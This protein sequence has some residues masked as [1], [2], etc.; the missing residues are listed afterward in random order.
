MSNRR[1]DLYVLLRRAAISVPLWITLTAFSAHPGQPKNTVALDA[2]P[3]FEEPDASALP[4][5]YLG[6]RDTCSSDSAVVDSLGNPWFR[7]IIGGSVLWARAEKL[8]YTADT[9]LDLLATGSDDADAIKKRRSAL[10]NHPEW[11]RRIRKAVHAGQICLDMSEDQLNASWGTPSAK[12]RSFILGV[13]NHDTWIY[14]GKDDHP[15]TVSLQ[16]GRVIG[17]MTP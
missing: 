9:P 4:K 6:K 12:A 8:R 14:K 1:V 16:D 11:P 3:C 15:V 2:V 17:W 7:L 10:Q 13:G 5:Q